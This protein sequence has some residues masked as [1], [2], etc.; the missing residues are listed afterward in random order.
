MNQPADAEWPEET[1]KML[2]KMPVLCMEEA[3]IQSLAFIGLEVLTREVHGNAK[4]EELETKWKGGKV[5]VI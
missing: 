2:L 3:A 1:L 5:E 4:W